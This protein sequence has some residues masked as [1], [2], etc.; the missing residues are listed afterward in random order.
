MATIMTFSENYFPGKRDGTLERNEEIGR[1]PPQKTCLEKCN[2]RYT[3]C[4][5]ARNNTIC[6]IS[7]GILCISCDL[8]ALMTCGA[9]NMCV[10]DA[11]RGTMDRQAPSKFITDMNQQAIRIN[12]LLPEPQTSCCCMSPYPFKDP[13]PRELLINGLTNTDIEEYLKQIPEI[14]ATRYSA[15]VGCCLYFSCCCSM[16]KNEVSFISITYQVLNY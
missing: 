7:L 10:A 15:P 6:D 4:P 11:D 16:L 3:Y 12:L 9:C 14:N 1:E 8:C 2:S 13:V 5:C